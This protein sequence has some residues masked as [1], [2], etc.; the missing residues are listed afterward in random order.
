MA[1]TMRRL[2]QAGSRRRCSLQQQLGWWRRCLQ[3]HDEDEGDGFT[4]TNWSTA[5]WGRRFVR[6]RRIWAATSAQPLPLLVA[7]CRWGADSRIWPPRTQTTHHRVSILPT[8][9]VLIRWLGRPIRCSIESPAGDIAWYVQH[10]RVG[11][12]W[13]TARCCLE[14][15]NFLFHT[16]NLLYLLLFDSVKTEMQSVVFV[17]VLVVCYLMLMLFSL[18]YDI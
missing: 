10:A 3:D 8:S 7:P 4:E 5:C 16:A 9:S 2:R 11:Y 12:T 15:L 13:F 17:A 14:I 18:H 1:M 6:G